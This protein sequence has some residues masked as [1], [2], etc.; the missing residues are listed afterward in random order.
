MGGGDP[1]I[2]LSQS[3]NYKVSDFVSSSVLKLTNGTTHV[4]TFPELG[5]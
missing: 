2:L 4:E 5:T 1:K 3:A